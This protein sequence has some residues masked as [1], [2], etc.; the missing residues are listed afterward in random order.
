MTWTQ[1]LGGQAGCVCLCAQSSEKR[2]RWRRRNG[3]MTILYGGRGRGSAC[4][5]SLYWVHMRSGKIKINKRYA[6]NCLLG[7]TSYQN[8]VSSLG[9][10]FEELDVAITH[11]TV[12]LAE[13][14]ACP[15]AAD[16]TCQLTQYQQLAKENFDKDTEI[17]SAPTQR[18][19]SQGD[20][21]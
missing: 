20:R 4:F 12:W 13:P 16:V 21:K 18:S 3:C 1:W 8:H 14:W 9:I 2:K 10:N 6:H 5:F 11:S 19:M 15:E 7:K 17:T